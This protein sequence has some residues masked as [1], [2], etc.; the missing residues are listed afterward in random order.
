MKMATCVANQLPVIANLPS[1]L[2]LCAG[3]TQ[4]FSATVTTN[5]SNVV[6]QPSY[7]ITPSTGWQINSGALNS[8]AIDV[9][10]LLPG[11]YTVVYSVSHN[12]NNNPVVSTT[13]VTVN[14]TPSFT[15]AAPPGSLC[16]PSSGSLLYN[17]SPLFASNQ[18]QVTNYA[19]TFNSTNVTLNGQANSQ[20]ATFSISNI[21]TNTIGLTATNACGASTI[22]QVITTY[23]SPQYTLP[24]VPISNCA[25]VSYTGGAALITPNGTGGSPIS[26]TTWSV[27]P[28][29]GVSVIGSLSSPS[30]GFTF[31]QPG[32]YSVNFIAQNAIGCPAFSQTQVI[33]VYG[34]PEVS[35]ASTNTGCA[36]FNY[37]PSPVYTTYGL[38]T[39][40]NWAVTNAAGATG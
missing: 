6:G 25:P 5:G 37:N 23:G 11:T 36:P 24:A 38:P 4:G 26:S 17:P 3:V 33:T 2:S 8:S 27:T 9:T 10:F 19:W 35:L 22:N 21:G 15:L 39:T 31:N 13:I 34:A 12:C 20:N 40:F 18:L 32:T 14:G 30:A 1:T 28:N 16:V 7:T 29:A